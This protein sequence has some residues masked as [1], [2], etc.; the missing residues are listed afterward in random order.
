M[1]DWSDRSLT[2]STFLNHY[3]LKYHA[4]VQD[5]CENVI[6]NHCHNIFTENYM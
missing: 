2:F 4:L 6:C 5:D 3:L 1:I